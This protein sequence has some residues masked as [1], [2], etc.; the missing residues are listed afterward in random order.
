M[1]WR[2]NSSNTYVLRMK[3]MCLWSIDAAASSI[4]N[5][6]DICLG[7]CSFYTYKVGSC[8][9]IPNTCL[10][11]ECWT[12]KFFSCFF[13]CLNRRKVS[14]FRMEEAVTVACGCSF[15]LE[16]FA[17]HKYDFSF[18]R[19]SNIKKK[20]KRHSRPQSERFGRPKAI[21][22]L[23]CIFYTLQDGC[24][25]LCRVD[26]LLLLLCLFLNLVRAADA[27]RW[28][29]TIIKPNPNGLAPKPQNVGAT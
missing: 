1:N 26:V 23:R 4:T 15:H 8:L 3:F 17:Q 29:R 21:S 14:P 2:A 19:I 7:F 11:T 12:R 16:C 25:R 27:M 6:T 13:L 28:H 9:G 10:R 18:S 22:P 20:K 5:P 24:M